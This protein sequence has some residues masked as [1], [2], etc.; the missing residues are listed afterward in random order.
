MCLGFSYLLF[1]WGNTR[2]ALGAEEDV[3]YVYA[4]GGA[5]SV[6]VEG[7]LCRALHKDFGAFTKKFFTGFYVR[8]GLRQCASV[9]FDTAEAFCGFTNGDDSCKALAFDVMFTI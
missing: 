7:T 9:T 6:M 8:K 5:D 3:V 2:F 1:F 4:L